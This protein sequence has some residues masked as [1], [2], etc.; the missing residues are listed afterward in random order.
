[1][2]EVPTD[3]LN[4]ASL[5]PAG[6]ESQSLLTLQQN[7]ANIHAGEQSYMVMPSDL[8]A[9]TS[10]RQYSVTFQGIEGAG[11]QFDT[12]EL[13]TT[14]Q[15]AIY[16]RFGAGALLT[17]SNID[18]TGDSKS[19]LSI[20]VERDKDII[21]EAVNSQVIPQLLSLNGFT[22]SEGDIPKFASLELNPP[23][24]GENASAIQ[25]AVS[26]GA[27]PLTP[28]V[29]N[30]FMRSIGIE[31]R[32]PDDVVA[33]PEKFQEYAATFMKGNTSRAGDGMKTGTGNGTSTSVSAEDTSISNVSNS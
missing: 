7:I 19:L 1:M 29:V 21:T 13:I 14:R 23:N 22:L 12:N 27:I 11:K 26:V 30:E 31:Y 17:D 20:F 25:R 24:I 15:K 16:N 4:R 3:I 9:G 18:V 6:K 5:D 33:D 8:F 32:I 10:M 2:L 28:E